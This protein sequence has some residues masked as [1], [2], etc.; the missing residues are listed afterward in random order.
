MGNMIDFL[1][2]MKPTTGVCLYLNICYE[3]GLEDVD[4]T[5]NG[6][7]KGMRAVARAI[8]TYISIPF[9]ASL[10]IIYNGCLA[11]SKGTI[12]GFSLACRSISKLDHDKK[13]MNEAL[14]HLANAATDLFILKFSLWFAVGYA[15]LPEQISGFYHRFAE[16]ISMINIFDQGAFN[17]EGGFSRDQTL[18]STS[19]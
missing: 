6:F 2:K 17:S 14:K 13:M 11:V 3:A 9:F 7:E 8:L 10:I 12:A 19:S 1:T 18:L 15:A 4:P 16:Y 5:E